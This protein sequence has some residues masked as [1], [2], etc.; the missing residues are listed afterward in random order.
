MLCPAGILRQLCGLIGALV[1]ILVLIGLTILSHHTRSERNVA[2]Q[3]AEGE[4]Y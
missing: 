1:V 3:T 4:I 2:L